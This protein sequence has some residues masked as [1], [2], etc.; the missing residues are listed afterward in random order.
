MQKTHG[1]ANDIRQ[2]L[3]II[4]KERAPS[5][6]LVLLLPL[7][8]VALFAV[9]AITTSAS[10]TQKMFRGLSFAP[11]IIPCSSLNTNLLLVLPAL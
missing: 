2:F 9:S 3:Y 4:H 6:D 5:S 11:L 1:L 10:L 8:P 7:G